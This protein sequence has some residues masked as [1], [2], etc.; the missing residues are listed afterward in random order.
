MKKRY[1]ILLF[2]TF[3]FGC[4]SGFN[5]NELLP[6][7]PVNKTIDLSLPQ[8]NNLLV[9]GGWVDDISGGI[10]GIILYRIKS[11]EYKAFDRA[12]PQN[13]CN[14]PLTFDGSIKL[15]CSCH[16]SEFSIL[17][18]S[19][20]TNGIN[21]NAREYRVSLVSSSVLRITNF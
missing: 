20:Q 17:D 3:I 7:I 8:Y 9:P 21:Y 18:G 13:S 19:P 1:L 10:K 12:C 15:K 16:K 6:N 2:L 4:N 11:N 14:S 5:E